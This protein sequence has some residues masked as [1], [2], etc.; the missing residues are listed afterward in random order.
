M[1]EKVNSNN[2]DWDIVI[3]PESQKKIF[4]LTELLRYKDLISLFVKRDFISLYKQT[5][6]G[7]L[8]VIIQPVLT[9][10]RV[11]V[12]SARFPMLDLRRPR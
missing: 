5:V 3:K 2:G 4:D 1:S 8:W 10:I 6:L 7:P 12:H 9:T 11:F